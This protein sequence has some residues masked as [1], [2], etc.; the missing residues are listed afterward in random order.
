M[1]NTC[2]VQV[3]LPD[4]TKAPIIK[5]LSDNTL[6]EILYNI[7]FKPDYNYVI[8]TGTPGDKNATPLVNQDKTM[9][10]VNMW[11]KD[12]TYTAEITIYKEDDNYNRELYDMYCSC[13]SS[14]SSKQKNEEPVNHVD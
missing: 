13:C 10:Q 1:S 4:G 6:R 14:S 5:V 9:L 3:Y 11:F 2:K 7:D 8:F 12:V